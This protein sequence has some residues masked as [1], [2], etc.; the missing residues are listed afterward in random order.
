VGIP[1]EI[2]DPVVSYK[3]TVTDKSSVVCL[4]KSQNKH[5]RLYAV[6]EPLEEVFCRAID[7]KLLKV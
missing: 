5:N 2:S 4:S 1:L 7:D 3:E 6:A